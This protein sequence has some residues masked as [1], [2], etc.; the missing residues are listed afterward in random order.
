MREITRQAMKLDGQE[1]EDALPYKQSQTI[2]C[3][4][5]YLDNKSLVEKR[6]IEGTVHWRL[7]TFE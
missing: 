7:R 2:A 4:L 3:S 6:L 1:V 5:N